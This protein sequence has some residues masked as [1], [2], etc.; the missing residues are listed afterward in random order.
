MFFLSNFQKPGTFEAT[1]RVTGKSPELFNP[2]TGKI[3]Q[4]ARYQSVK[5]GTRITIDIH[6]KS[7]SCFIVFRDRISQPSVV[8]SQQNGKNIAPANLDLF[9]DTH[10]KL[11]AETRRAGDYTLNMSDG[12]QRTLAIKQDS[13]THP[14][15]SPWKS[16]KQDEKGFS[17]LNE[18]TFNLPATFGK[19]KRV[20]LDLGKVEVMAKVTLNGKSFDTLWMPPFELDVTDSIKPG[21]NTLKVLVTSTIKGQPKLG[22]TVQFKTVTRMTMD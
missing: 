5:N 17:V 19:G 4:L 15:K 1:L 7:D 20:V 2:V 9:Y 8:S 22:K 13:Q 14:I 6:D 10:N 18:T 21:K 3:T 16:V 12:T 11:T